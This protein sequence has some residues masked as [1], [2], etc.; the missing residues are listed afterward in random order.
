MRTLRANPG[1]ATAVVLPLVMGIGVNT[2][3][4]SLFNVFPAAARGEGSGGD[5]LTIA[6][7]LRSRRHLYMIPTYGTKL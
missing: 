4:F 5:F 1:F 6:G 7:P 2:A 3:I